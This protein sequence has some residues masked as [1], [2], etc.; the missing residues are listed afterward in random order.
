MLVVIIGVM[1]AACHTDSASIETEPISTTMST[2]PTVETTTIVETTMPTEPIIETTTIVET[3]MP[4][5]PTIETKPNDEQ[6]KQEDSVLQ[7]TKPT[8]TPETKPTTPPETDSLT[9]PHIHIFGD[10]IPLDPN[11]CPKLTDYYKECE[12][13]EL[14]WRMGYGESTAI[15]K[16]MTIDEMTVTYSACQYCDNTTNE[17]TCG[18]KRKIKSIIYNNELCSV[19]LTIEQYEMIGQSWYGYYCITNNTPYD[20]D[21]KS[22]TNGSLP[23]CSGIQKSGEISWKRP[24]AT[25]AD[26]LIITMI[27][28]EQINIGENFYS[29]KED[30][31]V[32]K[33]F[34]ISFR[35]I[36]DLFS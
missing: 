33:T 14:S 28:G 15:T 23:P 31:N 7:E 24:F 11:V 2:D 36:F 27:S 35:N 32:N 34:T 8:T 20:C 1:M 19:T 21:I 29:F 18:E 22:D 16:T 30:G 3:T 4:T 12:C 17:R 5:E 6:I 13:G 25:Y 9:Q 10:Y 26:E